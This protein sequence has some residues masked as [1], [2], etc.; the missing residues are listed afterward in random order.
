MQYRGKNKRKNKNENKTAP[1]QV[2]TTPAEKARLDRL[3]KAADVP[4]SQI[5]RDALREHDVAKSSRPIDEEALAARLEP[6]L[7][8]IRAV[9]VAM[10]A[11]NERLDQIEERLS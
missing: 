7:E 6:V 1:V 9:A 5:V 8:P 4:V 2:R 3:A 10:A 11:L